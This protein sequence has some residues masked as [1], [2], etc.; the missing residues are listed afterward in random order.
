MALINGR[1]YDWEQITLKFSNLV[2]DIYGIS[3]IKYEKSQEKTNHYGIGSKPVSRGHGRET[4]TG[5]ITI[6][7]NSIEEIKATLTD[8]DILSLQFDV[9]V[10]YNHPTDGFTVVHKLEQCEFLAD[11]VDVN[12]GDTTIAKEY[13][14]VIGDINFKDNSLIA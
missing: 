11:G 5:S 12:E 3:A 13:E 7:M 6:D 8:G 9:I 1:T 14:L 4:Y 10:A 2:G